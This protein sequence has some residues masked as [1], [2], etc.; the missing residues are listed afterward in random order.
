M[1]NEAQTGT[2]NQKNLTDYDPA[3]WNEEGGSLTFYHEHSADSGSSN[4]KLQDEDTNDLSGSNITGD[5]LT[6]GSAVTMPAT[7]KDIDSVIVTA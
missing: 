5:D 1:I 7:A 6:R 4:T 2:G 3:E